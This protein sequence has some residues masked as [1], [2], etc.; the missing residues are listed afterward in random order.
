MRREDAAIARQGARARSQLLG[1]ERVA[2]R[3]GGRSCPSARR[4]ASSWRARSPR[5]PKLLL[6]DEPAG[7]LNHEEVGALGALIRGLRERLQLTVLLVEH[8]MSLVMSV[9]DRVVALNF[10]RR[11]RRGHAGRG[12]QPSRADPGL[13]GSAA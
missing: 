2:R 13:P 4:S 12:A 9:S 7:G 11:D 1:L 8:H 5:E 6:L 3:A 10:G